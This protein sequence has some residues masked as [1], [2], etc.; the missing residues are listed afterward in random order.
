MP[1]PLGSPAKTTYPSVKLRN[2]GH[3]VVVAL[4]D[5]DVVPWKDFA[6]N[7]VKV[8]ADGQPRTQE[9][10]TGLVTGYD[11]AVVTENDA[12]RP[13]TPGEIVSIWLPGHKRWEWVQA[14]K[15]FTKEVDRQIQTGDVLKWTYERD[16]APTRAGNNAKKVHTCKLRA[17]KPD[18][19]SQVARCDQL[20]A[21]KRGAGTPLDTG[22]GFDDEEP[23]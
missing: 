10:V 19:A 9:V 2:V 17:A 13:V 20:L 6:T 15:A 7:E 1:T 8:G 4:V 18:E 16:E 14:Q 12:D 23:F 22:A 21:D 3:S 11:G 5:V